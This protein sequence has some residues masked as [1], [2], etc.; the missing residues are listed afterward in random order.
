MQK[1]QLKIV[2]QCLNMIYHC[3]GMHICRMVLVMLF[4]LLL[5]HYQLLG[6]AQRSAST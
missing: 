5:L 2:F 6:S 4:L 1:L 3:V